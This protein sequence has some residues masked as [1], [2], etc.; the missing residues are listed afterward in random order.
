VRSSPNLRLEKY[1]VAGDGSSPEGS[2]RVLGPREVDL[3]LQV[4]VEGG[5]DHVSVSA[6][7]RCP[8]W[9]EMEFARKLCFTDQEWALQYGVPDRAH[10]NCHPYV[11]HWWRPQCEPLPRPPAWMVG[12]TPEV[13]DWAREVLGGT[14][15]PWEQAQVVNRLAEAAPAMAAAGRRL[16]EVLAAGA[17]PEWLGPAYV[18]LAQA[19]AVAE[20]RPDLLTALAARLGDNSGEVTG[21]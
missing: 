15:V 1:R 4:S 12:P 9:E 11:L 13:V 14:L 18:G 6:P 21:G 10:I 17:G 20:G 7:G 19:V 3:V 5:W 8:T 16:L 2:F